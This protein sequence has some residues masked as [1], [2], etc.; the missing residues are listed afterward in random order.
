MYALRIQNITQ[1]CMLFFFL[2]TYCTITVCKQCINAEW[3]VCIYSG[4]IQP[5]GYIIRILCFYMIHVYYIESSILIVH[6]HHIKA[7]YLYCVQVI[8]PFSCVHILNTNTLYMTHIYCENGWLCSDDR[9]SIKIYSIHIYSIHIYSIHIYSIHMWS[10]H[11]AHVYSMHAIYTH[12]TLIL[13]I[14]NECCANI[15]SILYVCT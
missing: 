7:V 2:V 9:Y 10:M 6:M 12:C 13:C 3:T 15:E 14:P 5:Y 11:T 8:H 1:M 4:C